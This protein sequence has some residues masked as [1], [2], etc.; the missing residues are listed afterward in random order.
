MIGVLYHGVSYRT[1]AYGDNGMLHADYWLQHGLSKWPD[2]AIMTPYIGSHDTARFT[3]IADYRGQNAPHDRG[4][5]DSPVSPRA[6]IADRAQGMSCAPGP[7][8]H[9][10]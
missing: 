1:F 6:H 3:T 10:C 9:D 2:G 8:G 7:R 4:M 5:A